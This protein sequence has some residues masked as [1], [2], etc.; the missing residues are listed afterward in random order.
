VPFGVFRLPHKFPDLVTAM[1]ETE[2][3]GRFKVTF[4]GDP[5][6]PK[7]QRGFSDMDT[8]AESVQRLVQDTFQQKL[9]DATMGFQFAWYPWPEPKPR[10]NLEGVKDSYLMFEVRQVGDSYQATLS[11]DQT[12]E[13]TVSHLRDLPDVLAAKAG[14]RWPSLQAGAIPGM[15]HWNRNLTAA[16]F[17]DA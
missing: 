17:S 6:Q 1:V 16:G 3:D 8:L 11:E 13:A 2:I 15:I 9:G 10:P 4:I 5:P 14:A 7:D 12:L